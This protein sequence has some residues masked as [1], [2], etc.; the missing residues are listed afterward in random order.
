M[1]IK[2]ARNTAMKADDATTKNTGE[3]EFFFPEYQITVTAKNAK[4]AEEKLK[5][6]IKVK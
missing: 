5:K 4:E 1:S 3:R 2:T 6:L